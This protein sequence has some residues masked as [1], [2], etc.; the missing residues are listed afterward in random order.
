MQRRTL[1]IWFILLGLGV[2]LL[3]NVFFYAKPIGLSFP[4][5][6]GV[7]VLVVLAVSRP[8]PRP[9]S[10]GAICGCWGRC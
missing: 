9:P 3:G 1:A 4:L 6:I 10:A 8:G 2:G 5:F 7:V